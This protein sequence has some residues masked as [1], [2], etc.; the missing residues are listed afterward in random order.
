VGRTLQH[1]RLEL[2]DLA[3]S[4]VLGCARPFEFDNE[5]L[6]DRGYIADRREGKRRVLVEVSLAE[7]DKVVDLEGCVMGG[8]GVET[9]L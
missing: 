3:P 9:G 8:G 1:A 6:G 7:L 2:S 4:S 5:R